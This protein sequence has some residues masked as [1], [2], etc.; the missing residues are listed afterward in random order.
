[1]PGWRRGVQRRLSA[2]RGG[3]HPRAGLL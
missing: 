2:R 1:M 3:G